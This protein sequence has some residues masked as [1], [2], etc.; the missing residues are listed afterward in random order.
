MRKGVSDR[1]IVS[2]SL[3]EPNMGLISGSD[4][5]TAV[6]S[7][8]IQ[9][10]TPPSQPNHV[11]MSS[12]GSLYTTP[13]QGSANGTGLRPALGRPPVTQLFHL[14]RIYS[15]KHTHT[16]IDTHFSD[17]N[18]PGDGVTKLKALAAYMGTS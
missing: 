9:M 8:H 18:N 14:E 6:Y 10:I 5:R 2:T 15:N 1:T 11:R 17:Q 4:R 3:I 12:S 7:T 16:H 13:L